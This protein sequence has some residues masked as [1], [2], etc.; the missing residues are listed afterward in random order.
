VP[1]QLHVEERENECSLGV[2]KPATKN[3]TI[4]APHP[5]GYINPPLASGCPAS[6]R[7][8]RKAEAA[9][10]LRMAQSPDR[11]SG[12]LSRKRRVRKRDVGAVLFAAFN[13]GRFVTDE[14]RM[15][16]TNV[17]VATGIFGSAA[18]AGGFVYLVAWVWGLA[19]KRLGR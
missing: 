15:D 4:V 12:D 11:S 2:A 16:D 14:Y 13:V 10:S 8:K 1:G 9:Y 7:E 6:G 5:S 19:T 17:M 3:G 18:V